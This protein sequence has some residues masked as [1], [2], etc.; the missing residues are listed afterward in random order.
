MGCSSV[1]GW[2]ER[3]PCDHQNFAKSS[4]KLR[5]SADSGF[6]TKINPEIKKFI[7]DNSTLSDTALSGLIEQKFGIKVSDRA[8]DPYLKKSRAEKEANNA[9]KVEAVRSK[10]LDDADA[11]AGKY[12]KILDEEI[13]S[14]RTLLKEGV[15][16]FPDKTEIRISDIKDRQAASQ[17]M[18]KYIS[19]VIEFVKPSPEK[20]E[21]RFQWL[22]DVPDD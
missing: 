17:A 12:L 7:Y 18:H 15:L 10:I 6:M 21:V 4:P 3:G 9:A 22:K 14:W 16:K 2:T 1:E 8:I 19:T 5:S 11:Y 20:K 13:E